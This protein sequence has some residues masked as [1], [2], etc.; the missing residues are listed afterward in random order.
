MA[1]A[2]TITRSEIAKAV[3]LSPM[4]PFSQPEVLPITLLAPAVSPRL[5]GVHEDHARTHSCRGQ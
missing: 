3:N 2:P 1:H 5:Q 4:T